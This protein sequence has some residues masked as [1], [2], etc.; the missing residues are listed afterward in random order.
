MEQLLLALY[1]DLH[2]FKQYIN[3]HSQQYIIGMTNLFSDIYIYILLIQ[4]F[5]VINLV[6]L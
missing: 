1:S 5:F 2:I 3:I 6:K 4:F